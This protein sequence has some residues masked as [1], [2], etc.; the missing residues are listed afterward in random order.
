M[1]ME[2]AAIYR[3]PAHRSQVKALVGPGQGMILK[4]GG[5]GLVGSVV[6]GRDN[7]AAGVPV[8]AVD[9]P[10]AQGA[11]HAAEAVPAVV[12]QGVDQGAARN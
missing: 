9:D 2:A 6:L 1:T 12:Q 5:K 3:Y 8:D 7:E 4:L 11:P 10:R